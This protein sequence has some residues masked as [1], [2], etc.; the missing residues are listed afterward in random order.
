MS[1]LLV[2]QKNCRQRKMTLSEFVTNLSHLNNGDDFPKDVLKSI[3]ISLKHQ[4][5]PYDTSVS[6]YHSTGS[7]FL[8]S[9]PKP[10]KLATRPMRRSNKR[11]T[12][13]VIQ[14]LYV[15]DR[16]ENDKK[17]LKIGVQRICKKKLRRALKCSEHLWTPDVA[18]FKRHPMN[19]N[20]FRASKQFF[21]V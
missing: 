21:I 15:L 6:H 19:I 12:G 14:C 4:P 3:Y 1:M 2:N 10:G 8:P 20:L 11:T 7:G 18:A 17:T 5:L 16:N 9:P 13:I